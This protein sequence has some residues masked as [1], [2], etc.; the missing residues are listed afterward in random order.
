VSRA[1]FSSFAA[2]VLAGCGC[3]SDSVKGCGVAGAGFDSKA[4]RQELENYTGR[5]RLGVREEIIPNHCQKPGRPPTADGKYHYDDLFRT[6]P[7]GVPSLDERPVVIPGTGLQVLY[8]RKPDVEDAANSIGLVAD[9]KIIGSDDLPRAFYMHPPSVGSGTLD[10]VTIVAVAER[11][12]AT[13]DKTFVA[14]FD[15]GGTLRYRDVLPLAEVAD[16]TLTAEAIEFIG[17]GKSRT[18][19]LERGP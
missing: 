12:R 10:G 8:G 13:T 16:A 17:C 2:V 4:T 3:N 7:F 15:G 19:R 9:G 5:L 1:I 11:S 6:F 14:I 18:I